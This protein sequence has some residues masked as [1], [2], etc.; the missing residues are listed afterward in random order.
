MRPVIGI[1]PCIADNQKNFFIHRGYAEGIQES[2]GMPFMLNLTD[3][4]SVLQEYLSICD[5]ILFSGGADIDPSRYGDSVHTGCGPVCLARD[6]MEIRLMQLIMGRTDKPVLAV[7][8]GIQVLNV[9]LGGNLYQDLPTEF[10]GVFCDHRQKCEDYIG[11]H[12]VRV[13]DHTLLARITGRHDLLVNSLHH[14][15][16]KQVAP[17]LQ[18]CGI[19]ED[20]VIESVYLPSHAFCLGVQWHPERLYPFD[21]SSLDLFRSFIAAASHMKS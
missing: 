11:T 15:A 3:N 18:V 12:H 16:I 20:G 6:A 14:Q 4:I 19:S 8:R 2:G 13:I 21:D 10:N 1:T 7:C 17:G 9:A 5:G